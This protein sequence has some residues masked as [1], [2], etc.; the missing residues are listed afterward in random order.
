VL[1]V[2]YV[3]RPPNE[4]LLPKT[5]CSSLGETLCG[6][7]WKRDEFRCTEISSYHYFQPSMRCVA[8]SASRALIHGRCLRL[9]EKG[10]STL[11][12]ST[13]PASSDATAYYLRFHGIHLWYGFIR[14]VA[15]SAS[16]ALEFTRPLKR[17]NAVSFVTSV[18]TSSV[19]HANSVSCSFIS[20]YSPVYKT[21]QV[22]LAPS[23]FKSKF[24]KSCKSFQVLPFRF[25]EGTTFDLHGFP[26]SYELVTS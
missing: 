26:S 5:H 14:S 12:H 4:I 18:Y 2:I 21:G 10:R 7:Y 16:R 3:D 22:L 15:I 24:K 13:P 6:I 1:H 20:S 25:D 8:I 17:G 9:P 23:Q 19:I 11:I